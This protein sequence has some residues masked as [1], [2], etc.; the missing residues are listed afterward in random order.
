MLRKT[1]L[2]CV[3]L[4]GAW[5]VSIPCTLSAEE[6]QAAW[7]PARTPTLVAAPHRLVEASGIDPAFVLAPADEVM[8]QPVTAWNQAGN[9]PL[10]NGVERSLPE[11]RLVVLPKKE[12]GTKLEYFGG[13]V[14]AR[15]VED[16][17][18][19][20]GLS[21]RVEHAWRL[22]I[23]LDDVRLPKD[24]QMWVYSENEETVGPFGTELMGPDGTL[25]TPSV[26]GPEIRLE[27]S[28]PDAAWEIGTEPSLKIEAVSELFPLSDAGRP[29]LGG[30]LQLKDTS[31]LQDAACVGTGDW[32]PIDIITAA[33]AYLQYQKGDSGYI[34]T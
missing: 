33:V 15:S 26:G 20:W 16:D 34:R 18:V 31:C 9:L 11:A 8:V 24:A 29:Q 1:L 5:A 13:G 10:R 22:R 3:S 6:N 4:F 32:P 21:L 14:L 28:V 27:I 12:P 19:V 7:G 23:R 25:W 30:E 17:A 2:V